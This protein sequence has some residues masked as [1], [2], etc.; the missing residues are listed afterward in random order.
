MQVCIAPMPPRSLRLQIDTTG[1]GKSGC[2]M[3]MFHCHRCSCD[4][5]GWLSWHPLLVRTAGHLQREP[6]L[7]SVRCR[8]KSKRTKQKTDELTGHASGAASSRRPCSS[9][10]PVES[11]GEPSTEVAPSAASA[12][13]LLPFVHMRR[14]VVQHQVQNLEA[15][16]FVPRYIGTQDIFSP[17][18]GRITG[19][20]LGW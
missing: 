2:D 18:Q 1:K 20:R 15:A 19:R 5:A 7:R 12:F 4:A 9:Q 13:R 16:P 8:A 14:C 3:T 6:G 10:L 11:T 17:L